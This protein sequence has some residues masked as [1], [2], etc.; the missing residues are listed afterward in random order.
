MEN[1][2]KNLLEWLA[3]LGTIRE[4]LNNREKLL[5]IMCYPDHGKLLYTFC[6]KLNNALENNEIMIDDLNNL[7][8]GWFGNSLITL[9]YY[10]NI[11]GREIKSGEKY[12]KLSCVSLIKDVSIQ[13]ATF[14]NSKM[15]SAFAGKSEDKDLSRAVVNFNYVDLEV[16]LSIIQKLNE[17][18]NFEKANEYLQKMIDELATKRRE[19]D[20]SSNYEYFHNKR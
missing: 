2:D 14:T 7:R 16:K 13:L 15:I 9:E 19:N 3:N 5:L 18:G 8:S 12:S 11:A 1:E 10:L 20:K 17:T 4:I 6:M